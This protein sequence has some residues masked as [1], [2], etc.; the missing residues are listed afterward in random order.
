MNRCIRLGLLL[1][2][3]SVV[4]LSA[5][6]HRI[7]LTAP[8][9]ED[10]TVAPL[11]GV[12]SGPDPNCLGRESLPNVAAQ[13]RDIGVLFVRNNDYYDDRLDMERMFRCPDTTTYPSWQCDP[14]DPAHYDFELSD[15]QF[16]SYLDN[17]FIPFFRLGG[18][19]NTCLRPHDYKG[20]KDAVER[21]HWIQAALKVLEHYHNFEGRQHV[22]SYV[23][24]WTEFPGRHFWSHPTAQFYP[25][26]ADAFAA[27]KARFPA[28]FVGGPG[29]VPKATLDV[30]NGDTSSVA[31]A[32]L[33]ELYRR[34]LKPDWIGWH[35][36]DNN[37]ARYRAVAQRFRQ[38][39]DGT[40]PFQSVPWAGTG[41]FHDVVQ[42]VD[43]YGTSVTYY[44]DGEIKQLSKVARDSIYNKAKG[45][46]ILTGIWIALQ[47]TEVQLACYYRGSPQGT[48]GPDVDPRD[49][50]ARISGPSLFFG[51]PAG[52]P[53]PTAHAFRLW[54]RIYREFPIL[55][56][57]PVTV[58]SGGQSAL[59]VL[60]ARGE[61]RYAVLISN[62]TKR[63][64]QYT[65]IVEGIPVDE[66]HFEDV[67][68]FAVNDTDD[69]RVARRWG[70]TVFVIP[71][72]TVQLVVLTPKTVGIH[73]G[74]E[75]GEYVPNIGIP[76]VCHNGRLPVTLQLAKPTVVRI[77][78]FDLWGRAVLPPVRATYGFGAHTLQLEMPKIAP[79]VYAIVVESE[80]TIHR[81]YFLALP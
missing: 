27:I 63:P 2:A 7:E 69:G 4:T 42:Y 81:Q 37:P 19:Y 43:A 55:L 50:R 78:V 77:G 9:P 38:L 24:I 59:W 73:Q 46:A 44:E 68:I 64:Q 10:S 17:G 23:D 76:K 52:T 41:F 20:P 28:L 5:Q 36:W 56:Q 67:S 72:Y 30:L 8:D 80:A 1:A 51:D 25:F 33:T 70:G 45:A 21:Q 57:G 16:R 71:G 13:Y 40:G 3:I 47:Y 74:A 15:A 49:P 58:E 14:Q 34:N 66:D 6:W 61:K 31:V 75:T 54:S 65:L 29:F 12:I 39:L 26:W 79:G 53:K 18:E 48:A 11:L 60:G 35:L 62:L 22:L 32:F